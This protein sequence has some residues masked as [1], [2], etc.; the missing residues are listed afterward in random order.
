MTSTSPV[1]IFFRLDMFIIEETTIDT[2]IPEA[3]RSSTFSFEDVPGL[4]TIP[5]PDGFFDPDRPSYEVNIEV[6]S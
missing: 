5:K 3:D 2:V 4:E 6:Q 1:S